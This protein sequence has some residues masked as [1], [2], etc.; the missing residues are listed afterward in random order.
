MLLGGAPWRLLISKISIL[1]DFSPPS[2]SLVSSPVL[3]PLHLEL[4]LH[5]L[6]VFGIIYCVALAS[7]KLLGS[8][9]LPVPAF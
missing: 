9:D 8:S 3:S 7:L 1:R 2:S 6:R 4:S 5:S